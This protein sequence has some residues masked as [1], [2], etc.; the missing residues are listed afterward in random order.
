M[1]RHTGKTPPRATVLSF[2]DEVRPGKR[3]KLE[4][5]LTALERPID[6]PTKSPFH[7]VD[8]LHFSSITIFDM[9][10]SET[11]LVF[12]CNFDGALEPFTDALVACMAAE[13]HEV[14][15]HCEHYKV[16]GAHERERI[17]QYLR[18][19]AV[20]ALAYHV[21]NPGRSLARIRAER[22][23]QADVRQGVDRC[24]GSADPPASL[25]EASQL[26]Q[27][28]ARI[29][30]PSR[31]WVKEPHDRVAPGEL[32][33]ARAR[34]WSIRVGLPILAL[35]WIFATPVVRALSHCSGAR[36][37]CLV[38]G[39]RA[40]LPLFMVALALVG[41]VVLQVATRSMQ[42]QA[43]NALVAVATLFVLT[44]AVGERNW[45]ALP[46]LIL[47][48]MLLWHEIRDDSTP[49][50]ALKAGDLEKLLAREDFCQQNHMASLIDVKSGWFRRALLRAV[51]WILNTAARTAVNGDLSGITSIHFA[52]WSLVDNGRKLL[53][54]T[55]Y[56]GTWDSYLDDFIMRAHV[57]L[58][59]VWSNARGFPASRLLVL[60][61]ASDGARFKAY[62]RLHQTAAT[63][64]YTAYPQLTVQQIDRASDLRDG[65]AE[66]PQDDV[67]LAEWLRT[68]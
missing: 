5:A 6:E 44:F 61:G 35:L 26:V 49:A 23:L 67:N 40:G 28:I 62:S 9:K 8:T 27:D 37:R 25:A 14:F 19:R 45:G 16:S 20:P 32:R 57:G 31:Q 15:V 54:L 68:C 58:T 12:E 1:P 13:L 42:R 18:A 3:A 4:R 50:S 24:L 38:D 34:L 2:V 47:I 65:L 52:H 46:L 64:W 56:D 22:A 10:E 60:G 39:I 29:D 43:F 11:W 48:A 36:I 59:G 66:P 53:F 51:L 7:H 41:L 55:N 63:V 33:L 21:G 17:V 30:R